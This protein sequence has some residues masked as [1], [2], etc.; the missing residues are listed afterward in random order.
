MKEEDVLDK[1][2]TAAFSVLDDER[3]TAMSKLVEQRAL[4]CSIHNEDLNKVVEKHRYGLGQHLT[5][6]VDFV[7]G[8][9]LYDT[10]GVKKMIMCGMICSVRTI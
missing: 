6:K 4:L 10:K 3:R 7:Q 2:E 9:L 5:G 8:E 1:M